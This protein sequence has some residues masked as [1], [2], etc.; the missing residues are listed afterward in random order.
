MSEKAAVSRTTDNILQET[1]TVGIR[2]SNSLLFNGPGNSQTVTVAQQQY[3][4]RTRRHSGGDLTRPT[5]IILV[6]TYFVIN[7]N[8]VLLASSSALKIL[9]PRKSRG[10]HENVA[11]CRLAQEPIVY[12]G[13]TVTIAHCIMSWLR[14]CL[15]LCWLPVAVQGTT[16]PSNRTRPGGFKCLLSRGRGHGLT[17]LSE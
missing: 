9:M 2:V 4:C 1:T 11:F 13:C 6:N 7:V 8:N 10:F 16:N 14:V 12:M 3:Q 15:F 17:C 5:Q